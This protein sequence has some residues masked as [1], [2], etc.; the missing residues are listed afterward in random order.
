MAKYL[1]SS[2]MSQP[3][4]W[5]RKYPTAR[6]YCVCTHT[7]GDTPTAFAEWWAVQSHRRWRA[8]T[9]AETSGKTA[10]DLRHHHVYR[11]HT[12]P[13]PS[14][15][16]IVHSPTKVE[17]IWN[18]RI[19]NRLQLV[20]WLTG[21]FIIEFHCLSFLGSVLIPTFALYTSPSSLFPFWRQKIDAL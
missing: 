6:T 9:R 18:V 12:S 14:S 21:Y 1:H 20:A 16:S 7:V 5:P 13:A 8:E 4:Y 11:G 19:S 2:Q 10:N 3:I 17:E 15:I